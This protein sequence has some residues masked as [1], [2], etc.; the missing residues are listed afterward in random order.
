MHGKQTYCGDHCTM[1]A[2]VKSLWCILE[3]NIILYVDY[4]LIKNLK[5]LVLGKSLMSFKKK[6]AR[7]NNSQFSRVLKL[8]F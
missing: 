6:Q 2:N 5:S 7:K 3:T 1:H 4:T 8:I